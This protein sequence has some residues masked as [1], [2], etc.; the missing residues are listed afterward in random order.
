MNKQEILQRSRMENQ[1]YGDECQQGLVKGSFIPAFIGLAAVVAFF[2]FIDL[3]FLDNHLS[4][5]VF[6]LGANVALAAQQWYMFFKTKKKAILFTAILCVVS[7][8]LMLL[9]V[10]NQYI[11]LI[12]E[13]MRSVM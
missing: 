9:V 8:V 10:L 11:P 5:R 1:E 3:F 13:Q 2:S 7:S 6:S 4:S 12:V